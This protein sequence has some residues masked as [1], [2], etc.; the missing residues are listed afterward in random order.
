MAQEG[1]GKSNCYLKGRRITGKNVVKKILPFPKSGFPYDWNFS[2]G[3]LCG[4]NELSK[5]ITDL[6]N[7]HGKLAFTVSKALAWFGWGD[8]KK[9]DKAIRIAFDNINFFIR[10]RLAYVR[11]KIR[12]SSEKSIWYAEV[13][14]LNRGKI[15]KSE[16]VTVKGR[17]WQEITFK[18]P[19]GS[20]PYT[21]LKIVTETPGNTIEIAQVEPCVFE[22]RAV[23][24]KVFNLTSEVQWAKCSISAEGWFKAFINGKPAVES[25]PVRIHSSA[26]WNYSL[27]PKLFRKGKNVI[28]VIEPQYN[29]PFLLDGA[30]LCKNGKY[31]RFDSDKSWKCSQIIDSDNDLNWTKTDYNDSSWES[32]IT[33]PGKAEIDDY[34]KC[35]FNPSYKGIIEVAPA[36]GRKEPVFGSEDNVDFRVSIPVVKGKQRILKYKIVNEMGNHFNA[37]DRTVMNEVLRL[38][39]NYPWSICNL[40][41]PKKILEFNTAYALILKL[42]EGE[43]EIDRRRYEFAYCGPIKQPV[44]DNPGNYEK[45]M[46]LKLVWELDPA[47]TPVTTEYIS[48]NGDGTIAESDVIETRLGKFRRT[49]T[50]PKKAGPGGEPC[51]YISFKYTIKN[52]GRPHLAVADYPEDS[53]RCQEM[54]ITDSEPPYDLLWYG[55]NSAEIGNDTVCMGFENPITNKLLR[56]HA[57]F[58]PSQKNGTVSIFSVGGAFGKGKAA[59]VGEIRIYEILNDIPMVKINDAPGQ[60]K[61]LSQQTERGIYQISQSCF[62]SPLAPLRRRLLLLSD[63]PNFYRDWILTF[64]NMIKRMRFAGENAHVCGLYMYSGVLYASQFSHTTNFNRQYNGSLKDCHALM[65]KMF[66][67]NGLGFFGGLEMESLP[68]IICDFTDEEVAKGADTPLQVDCHGHQVIGFKGRRIRTCPNWIHPQARK[69]FERLIN[70]ILSLYGKEQGFKGLVLKIHDRWGPCWRIEENNPLY[71]SY[72]D[73]TIS[74]FERESGIKIPVNSKSADRFRNRYEWLKKNAGNKWV[75]W[76]CD[77]MMEIYLWVV[78]RLQ[79][80]RKDLKL[81]ICQWSNSIKSVEKMTDPNDSTLAFKYFKMRGLDLKRLKNNP[82]I[83]LTR[84]VAANAA[85]KELLHGKSR[86]NWRAMAHSYAHTTAFANDGINGIAAN[87]KWVEAQ[88]PAPGGKKWLWKYSSTESWPAPGGKYFS[89]YLTNIF[90]RTNPVFFMLPMQDIVLWNGRE[91]Q[92]AKFAQA[93][94][95]LPATKY[96]RLTG[97]GLDKNIWI[98]VTSFDNAIWGYAANPQCWNIKVKMQL[99]NPAK[100]TDLKND[101]SFTGK[102]WEFT[103]GPYEILSFKILKIADDPVIIDSAQVLVSAQGRKLINNTVRLLARTLEKYKTVLQKKKLYATGKYMLES[104]RTNIA[105][106]DYST[107]YENITTSGIYAEIESLTWEKG[108]YIT[109]VLKAPFFKGR[110]SIDAKFNDWKTDEFIDIT[111]P[112]KIYKASTKSESWNGKFDLELKFAVKWDKEFLYIAVK[113][114]DS[115]LYP[116][117][118]NGDSLELFLDA[119][120]ELDYGKANFSEDDYNVQLSIH[121]EKR[122]NKIAVFVRRG[123]KLQQKQKY[124]IKGMKVKGV[125]YKDGYDFELAVPWKSLGIQHIN[126]GKKIGFDIAVID[127]DNTENV[128]Q[129]LIWS[130]PGKQVFRDPRLWGRI[131]LKSSQ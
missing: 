101:K 129:I 8:W 117:L 84:T 58:F 33:Y 85:L 29:E 9:D 114:K 111:D 10:N 4:I 31:V 59:K 66:E 96:K 60:R 95:S 21:A 53:E 11:I 5:T 86:G 37:F 104:C 23:Y 36:D 102:T 46:K 113:V 74:L 79:E 75:R 116:K 6:R 121:P 87:F 99:K 94:R 44:I 22:A 2:N 72:D 131:I 90:I 34:R 71:A 105:K 130:S 78:K 109:Q 41:I 108:D 62:S 126:A 42:Y 63:T 98:E 92:V 65:A 110:I 67:E 48:C 118:F 120:P 119:E 89:D 15:L 32:A 16:P 49:S 124:T 107:A 115:Q 51:N 91:N 35:W 88:V 57:V 26:I 40:N 19:P 18:I 38:K 54:R 82:N 122:G 39:E 47:I 128:K 52:P 43:Q 27:N 14:Q 64:S 61:W 56:H 30:L 81:V 77:K 1:L 70:E 80:T 100:I 3:T 69:Q 76:R 55:L 7:D 13:K 83:I 50:E 20:P 97:K 103:L 45:G 28:S 127:K 123:N 73:Y 17:V 93:Y 106:E 25:P 125:E 12:Q 24:R 68:E 112:G